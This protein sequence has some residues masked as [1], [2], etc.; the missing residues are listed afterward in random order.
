[1]ASLV[2]DRMRSL[3][4]TIIMMRLRMVLALVSAVSFERGF[5]VCFGFNVM[6][7]DESFVICISA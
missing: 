1:M 2:Y 3:R 5:G 6:L 7:M 4:F